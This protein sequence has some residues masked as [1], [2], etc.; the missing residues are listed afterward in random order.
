MWCYL[1]IRYKVDLITPMGGRHR[2]QNGNQSALNYRNLWWWLIYHNVP[3]RER[4][5]N[6]C[7]EWFWL[8][9]DFNIPKNYKLQ[10]EG[11]L[12]LLLLSHF[13]RVRLF[14]TPWTAAYQASPSVGFS[15]Q[16]YWSGVPLPSPEGQLQPPKWKVAILYQSK[17]TKYMTILWEERFLFPMK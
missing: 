14:G 15:R 2:G 1:G 7:L 13:S 3:S 12:L 9:Y 4:G 17:T 11:Q 10:A 16:E 5:L 6:S 8:T